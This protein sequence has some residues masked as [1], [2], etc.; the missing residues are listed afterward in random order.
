MTCQEALPFISPLYDGEQVPP[1]V[2]K[3][4]QSC[5]QCRARLKD[6]AAIDAECRLLASATRTEEG[7]PA[8]IESAAPRGRFL[9]ARALTARVMVPWYGV[10]LAAAVIL[11]LSIGIN[12][13]PAQ[14][15]V[16]WF[17]FQIYPADMPHAESLRTNVAKAGFRE[18]EAWMLRT[19]D[20]GG[21]HSLHL[22]SYRPLVAKAGYRE[23]M[24]WFW[25]TRNAGASGFVNDIVESIVS[26]VGI[27]SGRVRLAVRA[28][29]RTE[30]RRYEGNSNPKL[31]ERDLG[32]LKGREYTY[33]PGQTL[34]I[35]IEGG[36]TLLLS[37]Q[38]SEH[39]PMLAWGF[40]LEPGADQM[41]LTHF[42]LVRDKQVLTPLSGMS[43]M[44]GERENR[45]YLYVPRQGLFTF[46]LQ[47]FEGAVK[48]KASW[49]EATFNIH[50]HDFYLLSG[51]PITG[52]D[53][54][55]DIWVSL[56]ADFAA[57]KQME[58]GALFVNPTLQY[59][60]N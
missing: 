34:E 13:I 50:D 30:A 40:P 52:G 56:Q 55:H 53:Q 3:H 15:P 29:H 33:A 36:G 48:G 58:R 39:Q 46:A 5:P 4:V 49:S 28:R 23:P 24:A 57:P 19:D 1:D 16:L 37:G 21:S 6:Y 27:Q 47:P 42:M 7:L 20:T 43:T 51:S 60:H 18:P 59:V 31:L 38:V 44:I 12:L 8:W 22:E 45:I 41:I 17:Q 14:T 32:N 10:G 35:P 9:A 25:T 11:A 26:I 54:P 2:P